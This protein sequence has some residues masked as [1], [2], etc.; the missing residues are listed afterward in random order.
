MSQ[1]NGNG[2]NGHIADFMVKAVE[3]HK[4]VSKKK[5]ISRR[6]FGYAFRYQ[7]KR[8]PDA[9]LKRLEKDGVIVIRARA[10][11]KDATIYLTADAPTPTVEQKAKELLV[12]MKSS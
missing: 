3:A 6:L 4:K 2:R 10:D 11:G 9:A 7:Y 1:G 5:G 12:T 8:E